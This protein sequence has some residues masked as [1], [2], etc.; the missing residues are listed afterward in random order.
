MSPPIFSSARAVT[1]PDSSR[2]AAAPAMSIPLLIEFM[3][4]PF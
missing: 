2:L 1:E 3:M 4:T